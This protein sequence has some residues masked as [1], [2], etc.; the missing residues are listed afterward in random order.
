MVLGSG[1]GFPLAYRAS[2]G[3]I[4]KTGGHSALFDPG[5]GT[6][7][8]MARLGID[9]QSIERIFLTH[10]HPDH[11][12]DLIH[13]LFAKKNFSKRQKNRPVTIVG[14]VG[15]EIF[16]QRLQKVYGHCLELPESLIIIEELGIEM[17]SGRD[18]GSFTISVQSTR[19]TSESIAYRLENIE[20]K[21]AV[22]SGDTG[23][24]A[25]IIDLARDADVIVLECSFPE[26][27]PDDGHL[28]P[29]LAGKVAQ[30]AG[31]RKL[32]LTHFYPEVLKTDIVSLCRKNFDGELI[33][34]SDLLQIRV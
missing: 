8:Q 34:A 27:S 20:G 30:L 32:V 7:R 12:S 13:F 15:L 10:F 23:F 18:Y 16:F 33:L 3:I 4:L 26:V 24:C 25:E 2:P 17:G 11:T 6:L 28:T 22:F 19:H 21:S 1:T 5:P 31:V 9:F 14:P 29:S